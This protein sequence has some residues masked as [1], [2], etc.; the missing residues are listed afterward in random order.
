MQKE[1]LEAAR[2]LVRLLTEGGRGVLSLPLRLSCRYWR[3][4][5]RVAS[6]VFPSGLELISMNRGTRSEVCMIGRRRFGF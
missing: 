4:G 3:A 2:Q 1:G 6:Q 5:Q